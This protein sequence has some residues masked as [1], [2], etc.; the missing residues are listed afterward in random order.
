MYFLSAFPYLSPYIQLYV[1]IHHTYNYNFMHL[2]QESAWSFSKKITL[3]CPSW[4]PLYK[5]LETVL[6]EVVGTG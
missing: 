2:S 1:G 6:W 3:T 5:A 4:K